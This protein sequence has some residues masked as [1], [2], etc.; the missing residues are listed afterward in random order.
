MLPAANEKDLREVPEAIRARIEFSFVSTMD[1]VIAG[2]LLPDAATQLADAEP[3]D[4]SPKTE[5][6]G[7]ASAAADSIAPDAS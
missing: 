1:E 5:D 6:R 3:K 7:T 2:M 4:R